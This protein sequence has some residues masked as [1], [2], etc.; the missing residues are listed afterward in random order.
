MTPRH[1]RSPARS[2]SGTGAPRRPSPRPGPATASRS[3]ASR[4]TKAA[5]WSVTPSRL[6][7]RSAAA[8][9]SAS[10]T[11]GSTSSHSGSIAPDGLDHAERARQEPDVEVGA[12][13]APAV[14]V[15]PADV[16]EGE[17]GALDARAEVAERGRHLGRA[18]PRRS[19]RARATPPRPI[20]AGCRRRVGA[21]S[22]ARRTRR[23]PG[24]APVHTPHGWPPGS[25]RRGGSGT[26]RGAGAARRQR[27]LVRDRH[28]PRRARARATRSA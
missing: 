12:A 14:E 28:G 20:P 21:A 26:V 17:D 15:H 10:G 11:F 16:A 8:R 9:S 23:L 19:R 13:V 3:A 7:T 18:G 4:S 1:A 27:L 6:A 5:K 25:P 24:L 2:G 22:S